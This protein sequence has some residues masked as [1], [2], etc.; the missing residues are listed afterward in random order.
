MLLYGR[1]HL[2]GAV[3]GQINQPLHPGLADRGELAADEVLAQQHA[4]H[5]RLR[6]VFLCKFSEVNARLIRRGC[7]QQ[8]PAAARPAQTE[9]HGVPRRL[10]HFVHA[11]AQRARFQFAAQRSQK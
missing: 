2:I 5:R 4:K 7:E 3:E 10:L 1:T 11:A 6:R 9:Q 8:P